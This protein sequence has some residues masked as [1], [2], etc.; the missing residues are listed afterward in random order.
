[1]NKKKKNNLYD[2]GKDNLE[3]PSFNDNLI[4]NDLIN[5]IEYKK[6]L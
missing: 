6:K 3:F 4:K 5:D 1:M 2:L